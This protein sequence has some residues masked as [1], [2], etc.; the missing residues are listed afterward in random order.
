[1]LQWEQ[2]N[3]EIIL[4]RNMGEIMQ[5]VTKNHVYC[6]RTSK[7]GRITTQQLHLSGRPLPGDDRFK[8]G[9][10]FSV[11]VGEPLQV[12]EGR[13]LVMQTSTVQEMTI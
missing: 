13:E 12:F 11:G 10:R 4:P 2:F 5:I 9:T 7:D 3:S 6:V 8:T 1:M